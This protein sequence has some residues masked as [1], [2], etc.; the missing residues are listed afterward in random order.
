MKI[1]ALNSA[2]IF[3]VEHKSRNFWIVYMYIF[4]F[5]WQEMCED[6][7]EIPSFVLHG[8]WNDMHCK[9]MIYFLSIFRL[10]F[11]YKELNILKKY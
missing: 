8:I 7:S 2:F 3:S 1:T 10:V 6:S 4:V 11:Q 5:L 9:K